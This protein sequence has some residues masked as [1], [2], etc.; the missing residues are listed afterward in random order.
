MLIFLLQ[1][2]TPIR[3]SPSLSNLSAIDVNRPTTPQR[4]ARQRIGSTPTPAPTKTLPGSAK[5]QATPTR[6]LAP[7]AGALSKK[8]S[9]SH[10]DMRHIE[11]GITPDQRGNPLSGIRPPNSRMMRTASGQPIAVRRSN[12]R[13]SLGNHLV[14]IPLAPRSQS[15]EPS[16]TSRL[17]SQDQLYSPTNYQNGNGDNNPSLF[18]FLPNL[19]FGSPEPEGALSHLLMF[20]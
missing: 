8:F 1:P 4:N 6:T 5:K 18:S 13:S 12:T 15:V 19:N 16:T 10:P 3:K 11:G 9:T 2:T 14:P 17:Y 20:I 7:P